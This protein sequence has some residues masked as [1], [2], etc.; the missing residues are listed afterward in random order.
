[1]RKLLLTTLA[2]ASV[3]AY[4]Q[5]TGRVISS[6]P[7]VQQVAVQRQVCSQQPVAVQQQPSGAG[8]LLGAIA[9][10]GLGNVIGAGS[11]HAVAIGLG[12]VLGAAVGN[13]V[14]S[15]GASMQNVQSCAPQTSYENRTV[16]YNVTYE[17]NGKQYTVQMPNDP[18]PTVRLQVTPVGSAAAAQQPLV[19][20]PPIAADGTATTTTAPAVVVQ[21]SVPSVVY[22][23]YTVYQP[24]YS[25]YPYYGY[26]P[27]SLS[28]GYVWHGG[29]RHGHWR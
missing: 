27:I 15:R 22:P 20:A 16:G 5:E 13:S 7:V 4:A 23:S 12:T 29:G 6:T 9:G 8:A 1:M 11:G 3:G 2:L 10:A 19:T 21:E 17:Y 18:G 14:E 24:Y 28:F 25:Y 26:A